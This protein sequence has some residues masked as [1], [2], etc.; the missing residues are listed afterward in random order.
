M[1]DAA[2]LADVV[3]ERATAAS[4]AHVSAELAGPGLATCAECGALIPPERRA[5]YPAARTC[6]PCQEI[7]ERMARVGG[8]G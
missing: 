5:A 7:L 3:I 1:A 4:L 6:V 8:L 2:D